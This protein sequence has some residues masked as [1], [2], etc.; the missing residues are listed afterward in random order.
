[1]DILARVLRPS[2]DRL[3]RFRAFAFLASLLTW[4]SFVATAFLAAPA[5]VVVTDGGPH[6]EGVVE[7]VTGTP[8]VQ[9][10]AALLIA[11]LLVPSAARS[12]GGRDD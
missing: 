7:L 1:V 8:V 12:A 6:A 5:G 10:L 11:V 4:T 2:A 3:T 9:A